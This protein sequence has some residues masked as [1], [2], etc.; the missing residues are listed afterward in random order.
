MLRTL[1]DM[2]D[3]VLN[4]ILHCNEVRQWMPGLD[5]CTNR[6]YGVTFRLEQDSRALE[7]ESRDHLIP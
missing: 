6:M 4:G 5:P 7:P 2:A 1:D 3:D